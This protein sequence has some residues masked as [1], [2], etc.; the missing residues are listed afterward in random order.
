MKIV[1]DTNVLV[2]GLLSSFGP[3]A[4]VLQLLLAEK[5]RLCYDNRIL[6]EYRDVL[7]RP[8]FAFDGELVAVFLDFLEQAGELVVPTPWPAALPDADDAMFL[9][10]AAAGKADYLVTG[11]LRH[12]PSLQRRGIRVATPAEFIGA[13]D[14]KAL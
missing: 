4:Q 9:E 11:N 2:A 3:P 5:L 6:T 14:V 10:V 8:K 1:S 13:A 12:F 7:A